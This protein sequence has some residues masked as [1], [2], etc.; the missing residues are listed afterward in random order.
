MNKQS[1]ETILPEHLS[2][3]VQKLL[4]TFR[5]K[6]PTL[7]EFVSALNARGHMLVCLVCAAPFLLP[8]PLPGL[9]TVF[10]IVIFAAAIQYLLN[11]E[12]W[13]PRKLKYRHLSS[14]IL[15]PL[16]IK[17]LWLLKHLEKIVRPRWVFIPQNPLIQKSSA[18]LLLILAGLLSLPMPP[19]F[20]AP[21]AI[22]IILIALGHLEEDAGC[23][24]TGWALTLINTLLFGAFFILGLEGLKSL[25]T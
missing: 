4:D 5:S 15:T 21:P 20:N 24:L 9:S 7:D 13:I 3:S 1:L 22:A 18:I 25:F 11:R 16:F 14:E 10:G 23:L 8:I 2:C 12:P 6:S 17:L 19:G